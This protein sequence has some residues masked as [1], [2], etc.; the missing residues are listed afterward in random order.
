M[1]RFWTAGD[2]PRLS[3]ACDGSQAAQLLSFDHHRVIV[4]YQIGVLLTYHRLPLEIAFEPLMLHVVFNPAPDCGLSSD[5]IRAM[6]LAHPLVPHNI[7]TLV[8]TLT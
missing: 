7:Q 4:A 6:M 5:Q 2:P 8:D 3:E 1:A